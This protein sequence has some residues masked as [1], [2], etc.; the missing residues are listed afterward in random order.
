MRCHRRFREEDE[1]RVV[2]FRVIPGAFG[3]EMG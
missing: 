3:E 1:K 2:A